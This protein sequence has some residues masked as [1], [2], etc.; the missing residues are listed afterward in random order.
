MPSVPIRRKLRRETPSQNRRAEPGRE[1][2][3][4]SLPSPSLPHKA[5]FVEVAKF[6][7]LKIQ[8][9]LHPTVGR[10]SPRADSRPRRTRTRTQPEGQYSYSNPDFPKNGSPPLRVRV[11]VRVGVRVRPRDPSAPLRP[12]GRTSR[13]AP[14]QLDPSNLKLP[15]RTRGLPRRSHPGR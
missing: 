10:V 9:P 13:P 2:I 15:L 4:N 1:I 6:Q 8:D 11:G 14:F 12:C 5:P 7:S 3:G